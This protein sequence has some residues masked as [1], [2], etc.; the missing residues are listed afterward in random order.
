MPSPHVTYP[1]RARTVTA[2]IAA[3]SVAALT[4]TGVAAA[5]PA[6]ARPG[7]PAVTAIL[8]PGTWETSPAADPGQPVGMLAGIGTAL[9]QRYSTGIDVRT[10]A[11]TAD[12]TPYPASETD[13]VQQLSTTLTSLCASTRV[14]LAGYSQ[15]A[16]VAGDV[17]TAIGNNQGPL[18]AARVIAV[19]L[20]SDPRRDPNTPQLGTSTPGEGIAGPRPQSFGAL[21]DRVA[22]ICAQ[23]DLYCATT[24][25]A[26]PALA[27][28][29]RAFTGN[30]TPAATT[31]PSTTNV[32]QT[33]TPTAT[34]SAVA[35]PSVAVPN[36]LGALNPS[37]V[38][39][40][41]VGVLSGL[42][43]FL[44]DLPAIGG[45]LAQLPGLVVAG[46][47]PGMH[48]VAG[49][50]NNQFA[51]LV[52]AAAGIDLHLVARAL[53]L[54]APMDPSG[55]VAV[56][57]QIVDLLGNL[58]IARLAT[59]I[60]QAQDIAWTAIEKLAAGDPIGA[61]ATVPGEVPVVAD[62][63]AVAAQAITGT[64]GTTLTGL[65]TAYTTTSPATGTAL[66]D[67]ARQGSDA[68]QFAASGVHSDGYS[69]ATGQL[70]M[71]IEHAIDTAH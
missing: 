56:A 54:A 65:A 60:G 62:L 63:L 55:W 38:V 48:R 19:G 23:G 45:D 12:A 22:T 40:Q 33:P 35:N 9:Q 49:D 32:P 46:D 71:W 18:P 69:A 24:P 50:L 25:Q 20:L 39:A 2:L 28:I 36:P 64:P 70:L 5:D 17:A 42:A 37:E 34:P 13:G 26:S 31:D 57:A 47:I 1:R 43:G 15:G 66:A 41:V 14:V 59:D 21:A 16:D 3:V 58:D 44:A 6:P 30:L 11:Y 68:A 51:P 53:T 8:V 67:L 52:R 61:L 7:C 27:A 29:G 4:T 10:L